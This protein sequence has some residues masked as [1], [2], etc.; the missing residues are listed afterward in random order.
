R[1]RGRRQ[2]ARRQGRAGKAA[3]AAAA[4]AAAGPSEGEGE[5][6]ELLEFCTQAAPWPRL[7][8]ALAHANLRR[9]AQQQRRQ[10]QQQQQVLQPGA[11]EA[12]KDSG[13][14]G[15]SDNSGGGDSGGGSSGG[16]S[17][18]G[19][20]SGGLLV[21][22]YVMK[23][24]RERDLARE[25]LINLV[26]QDG[27]VFAPLDLSSPPL[28]ACL[29]SQ[30]PFHALLHKASDELVPGPTGAPTFGPRIQQLAAWVEQRRSLWRQQQGQGQGQGQQG[31]LGEAVTHGSLPSGME[32]AVGGGCGWVSVVD[33]LEAAARVISRTELARVCEALPLLQLGSGGRQEGGPGGAGH[34]AEEAGGG[35]GAR[36]VVRAPRSVEVT[37]FSREELQRAV[38]RLGVPPPYLVKPLPAVIQEFVNHDARIYKVYVAGDKVFHVVRPSIPNLPTRPHTA[39]QLAPS[40]LLLFDSLKSLPTALT[41]PPPPPP[42]PA[43]SPAAAAA[44]A[45]TEPNP[46]P[47]PVPSSAPAPAPT[48]APS[49]L[50]PPPPPAAAPSPAVL[51]AVA[52]QLRGSLGLSLFGFDVVVASRGAEGAGGGGG[53]GREAEEG[54]GDAGDNGG[55]GDVVE[56][57]VVDINY[58]PSYRGAPGAAGLFRAA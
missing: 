43:Q 36:M 19:D 29:T 44:S 22:G 46:A 12:D 33:P 54:A 51:Q 15:D 41:P 7:R 52:S 3:A 20:S 5:E 42:Q 6:E 21:V 17:S 49:P 31:R 53:E 40:G 27:L 11:A 30:L 25:G 18:G 38:A 55:G 45:P 2:Q 10:Q 47:A 34:A 32:A 26:P 56:L 8:L 35:G 39:R 28:S 13:G 9:E 1:E 50:S 58:F 37:S 24:S 48:P 16:G 4:G 23:G 57:V 14:S